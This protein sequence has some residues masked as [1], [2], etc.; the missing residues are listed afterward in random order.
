MAIDFEKPKYLPL[1]AAARI[2]NISCNSMNRLERSDETFPRIARLS[3][4][5]TLINVESLEAWLKTQ[6]GK[7]SK[8]IRGAVGE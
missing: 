6:E 1:A 5:K 7:K 3:P 2:Y 8:S 4:R